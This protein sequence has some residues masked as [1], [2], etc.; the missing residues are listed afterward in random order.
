M[1]PDPGGPKTRGSGS[2]TLPGRSP[3][4]RGRGCIHPPASLLGAAQPHVDEIKEGLGAV[5][6]GRLLLGSLH[7]LPRL[8]TTKVDVKITVLRIHEIL[9]RICGSM[10][11]TMDP[12]PDPAIFISDLQDV[13]KRVVLLIT[14]LR[15]IYMILQ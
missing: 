7:R 15:N 12:D 10:P 11:L 8:C 14:F 2:A 13:N 5:V 3:R 4:G 6:P 1:D 9:I